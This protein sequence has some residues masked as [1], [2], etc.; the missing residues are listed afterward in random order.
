MYEICLPSVRYMIYRST[1]RTATTPFGIE[2][3]E[4]KQQRRYVQ[5]VP[6]LRS[7]SDVRC[8][9]CVCFSII[10]IQS[11]MLFFSCPT[12][13]VIHITPS[14]LLLCPHSA[15]LCHIALPLRDLS[16]PWRDRRDGR[17][18]GHGAESTNQARWSPL[19][20]LSPLFIRPI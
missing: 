13:F 15:P 20:G 11:C 3:D 8:W 6:T 17:C 5:Y 9:Q 12:P 4:C 1:R 16:T 7:W 10:S 14:H 18:I 2:L 19:F